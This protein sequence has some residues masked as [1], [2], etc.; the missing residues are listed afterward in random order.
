MNNCLASPRGLPLCDTEFAN[1]AATHS[2]HD[3]GGAVPTWKL[4][5]DLE[6]AA[7]S[8]PV[9]IDAGGNLT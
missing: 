9:A 1:A 3:D 6:I 8:D 5:S 4:P 7:L 2:Q